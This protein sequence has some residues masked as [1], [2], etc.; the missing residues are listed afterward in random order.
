[1]D[2]STKRRIQKIMNS[3]TENAIPKQN[4]TGE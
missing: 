4:Q 2:D 1:M 3:Y